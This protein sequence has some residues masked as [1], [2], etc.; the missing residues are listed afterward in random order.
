MCV[1]VRV[2][3]G[4][5][6]GGIGVYACGVGG[7]KVRGSYT[8]NLCVCEGGVGGGVCEYSNKNRYYA[9]K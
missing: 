8:R 1:C 2:W 9:I 7:Y 4:K 5:C 3:G 6:E